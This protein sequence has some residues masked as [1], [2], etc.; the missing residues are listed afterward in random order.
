[1]KSKKKIHKLISIFF[2][3]IISI[4]IIRCTSLYDQSKA[5]ISTAI[6]APNLLHSESN[7]FTVCIDAGHGDWDVGA[8][9]LTG[10]YEK[11]INL[12]V[13]LKLGSLLD[14][15]NINVIYTRTSDTLYWS[16]DAVENLY[17]RL[18]ISEE[19][20]ADLFISIH[21]NL[22]DESYYY[23][24]VETWYNSQDAKSEL[25]AALIQDELSN[26]EYTEDRGLKTYSSDEP[27][28]VLENNQVPAALVE[29]GFLSNWC[30]ENFLISENGQTLC[31]E[32][33]FNAIIAF[34]EK[35]SKF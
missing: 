16:D 8:I 23:N 21:C 1:M 29:L 34:K 14:D 19:G 24:G 6:F 17:E 31:A 22:S 18:E 13:T 2:I 4:S 15:K 20:N 33:I 30:D 12:A 11:D 25:L 35:S 10:S 32:A 5:N 3:L 27:L 9:G 28:A 26:L 7:K